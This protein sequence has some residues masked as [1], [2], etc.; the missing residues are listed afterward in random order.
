M[1]KEKTVKRSQRKEAVISRLK[2]LIFPAI[3]CAVIAVGV[4]VVLNY[5]DTEEEEESIHVRGYDGG[6][7]DLVLENDSLKLV[8]DPATT[9]FTLEVKS[10]GKVWYSNPQ[11]ADS[12]TLAL[13][14]EKSNLKSTLLMSYCMTGG[15]EVKF[16]SYDQ[17][18]AN[19][20]Y[21]LE[22]GEDY[23]RVKYSLGNL[24]RE[25]VIPPVS[26]AADLEK[27][28][29]AMTNE[30]RTLIKRYYKKYDV[31]DLGRNDNK[32]ELLASY[33]V[34]ETEPIY[35]LREGTGTAVR[36]RMEQVFE[37]LGYT[38]E[39]FEA[40]KELNQA[41]SSSDKPVFNVDMVYRLEDNDL[42]VEIPLAD[43]EF[44]SEYPIYTITPL[45]YFGAGGKE[46]EGYILVPE[47]GGAIINFN[48]GKTVQNNYYANMYG[49]DMC[50]SRDAVVH[51]TRNYFNAFGISGGDASFLCIL[52]EGSPYASMQ[53]NVS[54]KTNS[55][56]YVNSVYSVCVRQQYS[57]NDT[58]TNEAIYVYQKDLPDETLTQRYR[59]VDS[60]DYTDMAKA[61]QGYLKD[62]YGSYFTMND[63][64]DTPVVLELVGAVDK[65]KQILGVPVSRPLE[66]T[67]WQ[68]AE[69]MLEELTSEGMSNIS[70]K[71]SGWCNGGVSQKLL[72]KAKAVSD[73]GGSKGLKTMIE[74]AESLGVEVYL[75]GVTQ[76]AY[77][78]TI[79][80]GFFSY[81]D[82]A[83]FLSKERA[84]L[85]EY[86]PITYSAAEWAD[87]YWL[88]HTDLAMEM[89]DNLLKVTDEYGA[90]VS[91]R[92]LGQDL[93]SDF[94]NKKMYSR[95]QVKDLQVEKLKQAADGG[96]SIM[97]NMGN[98]YAAVYSDMITNMDLQGSEYTILD[99]YVPFYQL[100]VHGYLN[101]TGEAINLAGDVEEELL[102]SAEY[103]AGL[104]FTL[105]QESAF[106]LQKTLYTE[107]FGADYSAWHDKMMEIY[108]R[109]N[110]ELGHTYNQEM[111]GHEILGSGLY[112]TTYRDGT[113]VYVNYGYSDAEAAP[114]V[115]VP[116]RDYKVVR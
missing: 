95:Q 33:P 73:L 98:E 106:T 16:N 28:F 1:K 46:D 21:E 96:R 109:Y 62:K 38:Y 51:N 20:L 111:T 44:K 13:A 116:A 53:A 114:G 69:A 27:W 75:D 71:L 2:S 100:A 52:E 47:G 101:Y 25:Y 10:T 36:T 67:T 4:V 70:V 24:E 50:L 60:P 113:K 107:Y 23:I 86:S 54:G 85:F 115:T 63:D 35:V 64:T 88:L 104:Q 56:N 59:F 49:W 17:S 37:S 91:F 89:A 55:Y 108:T 12:D 105:M 7:Q 40:D 76:Y 61:Y 45:P 15:M 58:L 34:L 112:C 8:M 74:K 14:L 90:G 82:A 41:E 84:E 11:D 22:T 30:D 42:V 87:S 6:D 39:D 29:D 97:I 80:D 102:R 65:V 103:G 43:L 78:S 81:R 66:L 57:M 9:Q 72:K 32:E 94:Y 93:S 83:R 31:N 5:T 26:R 18:T 110:E 48:N 92:D 3:L 99:E 77:D 19:G 68:E 79:F